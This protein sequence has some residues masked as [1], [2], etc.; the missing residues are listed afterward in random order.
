[1]NSRQVKYAIMLAQVRNFSQVAE[2]LGIS[3]PGLS[4]HIINLEQDLGVKLFD[5][6]TSPLTLTP[7][8]EHFIREAQDL[9][10]RENH[11]LRS[12]DS[13]KSGDSGHLSIGVTHFQSL[14]LA[15]HLVKTLRD[16]FPQLRITLHE[17]VA[18]QLLKRAADGQFDLAIMNMPLDES[19]FQIFPMHVETSVLA[20]PDNLLPFIS[21]DAISRGTQFDMLDL[22]ACPDLPFVVLDNGQEMRRACE[23]LCSI[24]GIVP[25]IAAQVDNVATAWAL[26]M[27]GVGATLAPLQFVCEGI[28][29]GVTVFE[30][31]QSACLCHPAVALR[32]GQF[33]SK[34]ARFAVEVLCGSEIASAI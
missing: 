9:L 31:K 1:M 3:Q 13:Y 30:P 17:C 23:Q 14:Y 28:T 10:Q 34:Y 32:R 24:A 26:A 8:G 15:P 5:R 25:N 11:L 6:N 19:L 7:A 16:K 20:V 4:K 29:K 27:T 18:D 22:S 2:Q 12:M 33:V 21:K